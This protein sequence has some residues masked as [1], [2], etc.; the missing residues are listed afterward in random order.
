MWRTG[1]DDVLVGSGVAHS[2]AYPGS[3]PLDGWTAMD[4]PFP[5]A[6]VDLRTPNSSSP[7]PERA[8]WLSV[9]R[10][11]GLSQM[12]LDNSSERAA[13]IGSSLAAELLTRPDV[14]E[15]GLYRALANA[16]GVAICFRLDAARMQLNARQ[17]AML[18]GGSGSQYPI[19]YTGG[20]GATVYLYSPDPCGLDVFVSHI[21][22]IPGA[23]QRLVLT[24][25]CVMRAALAEIARPAL[26]A[27]ARDRLFLQTP[28]LSARTL[29]NG[30]QGVLAGILLVSLPVG[31][32]LHQS[33]MLMAIHLF[34]TLFFFCGI[35]I[36][37]AAIRSVA[38]GPPPLLTNVRRV[39]L[40]TILVALRHEAAIVPELLVA[41]GKV[42]W[43]RSR[44]EIKFVCEADDRSTIEAI[45][46]V[47]LRSWASVI[48]VPDGMLKTKPNA[49]CFALPQTSGE[50]VVLYDA[51][52]RPAP[53]QLIEAWRRFES[54][55][56]DLAC[57]QAPLHI[58]NWRTGI[59]PRMFALE[60][61]SLFRRILPMLGR[62]GLVMP[63]GG[64]SNHFRRDALELVGAWDPYN[65]TEDADL[66]IRLARF[67]FRSDVI[68]QPTGEDA[69]DGFGVWLRQRSRW[70]KGWMHTLL[71][72]T[73][74]PM[75]L[76][77]SLGFGSAAIVLLMMA[78]IVVSALLHPFVLFSGVWFAVEY[79]AGVTLSPMGQALFVLDVANLVLGYSAFLALGWIAIGKSQARRGFWKVIAFTPVYWMMLSLAAWRGLF[80][81]LTQPHKWEKTPHKPHRQLAQG[82]ALKQRRLLYADRKPG[83]SPMIFGSSAPT[84]SPSRPL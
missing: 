45:K 29:A 80:Q 26:V 21:L 33:A 39:P 70:M 55:E 75:R 66:G 44:L 13:Q 64:T 2:H 61:A 4:A 20:N 14:S 23:P 79:A 27:K 35:A 16:L 83:P 31:L 5:S 6:P 84:T 71:V 24:P 42:R 69:P 65:V 76:V 56:D 74:R 22:S 57:L 10:Q 73:R 38:A 63:L 34:A 1:G 48:E 54:S 30:W 59:L 52:D 82:S 9:A 51:E 19:R 41:L 81:L 8:I 43:P 32:L 50:F 53:G 40:Y 67:G 68:E 3:S 78:G 12:E 17:A 62:N 37:L 7:D 49:L 77:T 58:D 25:R 11:I 36:R 15:A 72:H 60:Y 46:A 47:G 18:L 28:L